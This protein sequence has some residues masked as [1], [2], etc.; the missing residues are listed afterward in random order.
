MKKRSFILV[1]LLGAALGVI[2]RLPLAW[3]A[4]HIMPDGLGDNINY[5]GT[6]WR[7]KITGLDFIGAAQYKFNPRR[8]MKGGLPLSFQTASEAMKISGKASRNK[9]IGLNFIGQLANLPTTDGR[10]KGLTGD[11]NIQITALKFD[12][13]CES[14]TGKASTD[15]LS[16]NKARWQWQGPVLSGPVSCEHGDLIANLTGAENGQTVRADLRILTNGAYRADISVKTS[17]TEAAIVLPLYGFEKRN[18]EF[19]LTEQG[20]WR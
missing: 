19:K 7:G 17:L 13:D 20:K 15:F 14:A 16:R 9:I 6:L 4:P 18:G 12:K 3:V 5:S 1:I 2:T 10:L 8:V 11:V